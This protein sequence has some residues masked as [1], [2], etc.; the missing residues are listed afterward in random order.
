[1]SKA[2]LSKE[3]LILEMFSESKKFHGFDRW[4]TSTGVLIQRLPNNWI[5][6]SRGEYGRA[7]LVYDNKLFQTNISAF[8]ITRVY[9]YTVITR[10]Y[11]H[12]VKPNIEN[13]L[14]F[15]YGSEWYTINPNGIIS[16]YA[17]ENI[18]IHFTVAQIK[19]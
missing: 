8:V 11:E 2:L 9:S 14:P 6:V 7:Q 4:R 1:M 3:R 12:A 16:E 17:N 18:N 10:I 19:W 15:R 5:V 13:C